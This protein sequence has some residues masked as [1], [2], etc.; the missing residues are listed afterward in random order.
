MPFGADDDIEAIFHRLLDRGAK[1]GAIAA[2]IFQRER[3][4]TAAQIEEER[5]I[6]QLGLQAAGHVCA[7]RR[8]IGERFGTMHDLLHG[9]RRR[10]AEPV[11]ARWRR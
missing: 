8:H 9:Q 3:Q 1:S 5:V 11:R 4:A 7:D 2:A 6:A 10:G